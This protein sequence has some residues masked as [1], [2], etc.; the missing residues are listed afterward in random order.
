MFSTYLGSCARG[1]GFAAVEEEEII[2]YSRRYGLSIP[3]YFVSMLK[4][5]D[6]EKNLS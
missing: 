5:M 4:Y 2:N 3:K 1:V 6:G